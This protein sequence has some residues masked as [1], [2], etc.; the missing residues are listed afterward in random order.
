LAG[1]IAPP[2]GPLRPQNPSG[3][4]TPPKTPDESTWGSPLRRRVTLTD[5]F[6]HATKKR[7]APSSIRTIS[8]MCCGKN[9]QPVTSHRSNERRDFQKLL[10]QMKELLRG[11]QTTRQR[12]L[13][14]RRPRMHFPAMTSTNLGEIAP[15]PLILRIL[16]PDRTAISVTVSATAASTRIF[17]RGLMRDQIRCPLPAPFEM[18][19]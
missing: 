2:E 17:A 5:G 8:G 18:R 16:P 15:R 10:F 11:A 12:R 7:P 14:L 4:F 19:T 1:W 13:F 9:T 6:R 3:P